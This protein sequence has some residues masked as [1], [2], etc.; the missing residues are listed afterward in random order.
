MVLRQ[1]NGEVPS[2]DYTRL[3]FYFFSSH[4]TGIYII[5]CA[6]V[7]KFCEAALRMMPLNEK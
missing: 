2:C 6:M 7:V 3:C 1:G 5:L 4:E